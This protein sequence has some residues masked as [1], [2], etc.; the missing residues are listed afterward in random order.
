MPKTELVAEGI[1]LIKDYSLLIFKHDGC[2]VLQQMIK[3]GSLEQ[4]S[5]IIDSIK[6][7]FVDLL[8]KKYSFKLAQK[9]YYYAPKK[10]QRMELLKILKQ[11]IPSLIVH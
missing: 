5:K 7:N 8:M 10:S 9:V 4:K 11:H 1:A 2:R 6:G 3:H